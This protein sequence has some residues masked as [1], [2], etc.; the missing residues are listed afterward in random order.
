MPS[1]LESALTIPAHALAAT[2]LEPTALG[3]L[4]PDVLAEATFALRY[5]V[6]DTLGEGGMGIVRTCVDR[7]IGRDIALK[8]VKPGRG[9]HGDAGTRFLREACVQGQLEHPAIVPVYDL[10]RDPDGTL[11]FTMK[12]IRGMTFERIVDSLRMGE[13]DAARQFSRRK[14]LSAFASVCQAV[15]FAHARGVVHRDLKPGNVMLG[16]FGEVYVLDWGLAKVVGAPD[17]RLPSGPP[18]VSGSD[19]GGNTVHGAT[20]GTPGYMSPEQARGDG[21]DARSDVYALGAILFELLALEPLHKHSTPQVAIDSTLAGIEAHPSV[22]SPHLDVPPELDAVCAKAAAL[23]PEDRYAGVHELVAAVERYLDGDRDLARRRDLAWEHARAAG[24]HA[25]DALARHQGATDARAL[26]LREVGRAIALDP[27]NESA[28]RTLMRLMT[29]PPLE[30]PPE[31]RATMLV[32]TRRSMRVGSKIAA[33]A[34]LTWFIYSPL[35][36]WMGM[37]SWTAWLVGSAAWLFAAGAAY[38]NVRRPRKDGRVDMWT[39][40]AGVFA[41]GVTSTLFGPYVIVPSMAAIGS[42][43]LHLAPD[44]SRRVTIVV[45]NCLAIAVPAGLQWLGVLPSSYLFAHG[46]LTIEPVMLSFPAVP[47]H[48]FLLVSN[49]ALVITGCAMMAR[50]R[51]TLTAAEERLHVQAWQL[52]QLVPE[53]A[54]PASAPPPPESRMRL[55]YPAR[56]KRRA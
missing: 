32:E 23:R 56:A 5:E 31:A 50:F 6:G 2:T 24:A 53:E 27:T 35:M 26:A 29:Q 36:L 8:S 12:R 15:D 14:L 47:T 40:V 3:P 52:R 41:V 4:P 9:S 10:G 45:L 48:V 18:I 33:A 37:R 34:Y 38:A 17:P 22:R 39:T 51:N 16:D 44:R 13:E 42:M 20:M 25:S 11:Y 1:S 54:R 55:P 19:P 7:R 46:A 21:V 49:V 30:M 28:V 43:L